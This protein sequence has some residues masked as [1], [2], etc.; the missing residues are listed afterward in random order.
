MGSGALVQR[1]LQAYGHPLCRTVEEVDSPAYDNA[2]WEPTHGVPIWV[3][4][5]DEGAVN[6]ALATYDWLR[7]LAIGQLRFFSGPG[8]LDELE[9]WITHPLSRNITN[10]ALS[11][12]ASLTQADVQQITERINR[13]TQRRTQ[14]RGAQA[15]RRRLHH[16]VRSGTFR[17]DTP[18]PSWHE[19]YRSGRRLKIL[20]PGL[21]YAGTYLSQ[22]VAYLAQS[23]ERLGHEV[24][25]LTENNNFQLT[26]PFAIQQAVNDFSPD[27]IVWINFTRSYLKRAGV[28]TD[29]I[30]YC[31]WLQDP[32]VMNELRSPEAVAQRD[33]TDLYFSCSAEWAEELE[34]LG[35]G[36]VPVAKVP[37][38]PDMFS[39]TPPPGAQPPAREFDLSYVAT[40]PDASLRE[41][42]SP[43]LATQGGSVVTRLYQDIHDQVERRIAA[44]E[45]LLR[46][47]EY[48]DLLF[49]HFRRENP[50][51]LAQH[52]NDPQ[53]IERFVYALDTGPGRVAL[54]GAPIAWLAEAGYDVGVFGLDWRRHPVLG[55]HS[56][57]LI[58]YGT[59]L[60]GLLRASKIHVC[61][62]SHWTLT[63]KVLDCLATGTFPLIRAVDRDRETGPIDEWYKVDRD[64]V[65]FRTRDELLDKTR[66]YLDHP[67][68]RRAIALRGREITLRNF[69]YDHLAANMLET[70]RS[71]F[72]C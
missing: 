31:C 43:D 58:P 52:E 56:H 72:T 28:C 4:D 46:S 63:M 55:K 59:P 1:T 51:W 66:Y 49:K 42:F 11:P 9:C 50:A 60:A 67:E 34:T 68:E 15:E 35:Y 25:F 17:P 26:V 47:D 13:A 32:P 45:D 39:P 5:P 24:Y 53:A 12:D 6:R 41:L 22:C 62:H 29:G 69:T 48:R 38:H 64:V 23:F 27:L 3:I 8:A 70:V 20:V 71:R 10:W 14:T 61:I 37:T 16:R 21:R 33:E 18:V 44:G 19:R 54:R 36:N 30:P 65:L 40:V 57:G 7:A 2:E